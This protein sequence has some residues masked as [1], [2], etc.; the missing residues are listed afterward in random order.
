M[1][2]APRLRQLLVREQPDLIVSVLPVVNRVLAECVR[3]RALE[4]VLT[5]W[6]GVHRFWVAPGV[7]H[8]TAPTDLARLDCI[9][10]GAPP[11]AVEVV[12]LPVRRAFL[13]ASDP[14]ERRACLSALGL[15]P[16][17]FTILTMVGAEGSPSTLRNLAHLVRAPLD[18]QVLVICGHNA[19]LRR[20]VEALPGRVPRRAVGFVENVAAL[21]RSSDLLVTKAGGM[22]LAEAFCSGIPVVV[23]DA[24]PGQEAGNL[25]FVLKHQA[26]EYAPRPRQ[27][28]ETV[29]ALRADATRRTA[30]AA[31]ARRLARPDAAARIATGLLERLRERG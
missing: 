23:D 1:L 15:D 2:L 25:A 18:A 10:Y 3:P 24:L 4:V 28:A 26:V 14:A 31:R 30:L 6:Q 22:T 16:R 7:Q 29:L 21:M 8:Y 9:R 12:G 17:R 5:D 19:G 13:A 11:A 20:R 27:L